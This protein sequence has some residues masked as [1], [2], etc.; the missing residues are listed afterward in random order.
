MDNQHKAIKTTYISIAGNTGIALVKWI[1]GFLGNSYGMIADAIESTSD[2][3]SS[4]LTLFGLR[5]SNKPP[6]KNHPYGHGK[7]EPIVTFVV[8]GFLICVC[9]FYLFCLR[10]FEAFG[11]V[12]DY[13]LS[14]FLCF[15]VEFYLSIL[16][17]NS[18]IFQYFVLFYYF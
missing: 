7:A 18:F 10:I 4:I 17:D 6:D 2:I 1:T 3:L 8:V 11:E 14:S 9:A 13:N 16:I 15:V 12:E 5:Y